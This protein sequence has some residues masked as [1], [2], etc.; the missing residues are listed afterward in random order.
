VTK[1][2]KK[3]V[4][5]HCWLTRRINSTGNN[6]SFTDNTGAF[7]PFGAA[8]PTSLS[9]SSRAARDPGELNALFNAKGTHPHCPWQ[10]ALTSQESPRVV[11]ESGE[12]WHLIEIDRRC[13][14]QC[15]AWCR[16]GPRGQ[17]R[18]GLDWLLGGC[19]C[20]GC[21]LS[22]GSQVLAGLGVQ[23]AGFRADVVGH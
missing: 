9:A 5:L 1:T 2:T 14:P 6:A 16:R 10:M 8:T 17:R 19:G 12:W 11:S 13:Q 20:C 18:A 15:W 21:C 22:L 7:G 3:L 4:G 23:A